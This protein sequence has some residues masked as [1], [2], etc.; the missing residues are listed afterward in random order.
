MV[1]EKEYARISARSYD[2]YRPLKRVW[3]RELPLIIH[4]NAVSGTS[5]AY[6]DSD[7]KKSAT[8]SEVIELAMTLDSTYVESLV[9]GDFELKVTKIDRV[10]N[11]S[12]S[13][14]PMSVKQEFSFD[15]KT[16]TV[17][18]KIVAVGIKST[19]EEACWYWVGN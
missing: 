4:H 7:L 11:L 17:N 1:K 15:P 18:S 10:K 8:A 14:F 3:N 12:L 5:K 13:S 16:G 2:G 6:A 19:E 9:T